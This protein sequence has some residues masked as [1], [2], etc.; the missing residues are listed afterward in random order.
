MV[1][2][3]T[4]SWAV[5][6]PDSVLP[7]SMIAVGECQ[8]L[9]ASLLR[10]LRPNLQ[11]H[12]PISWCGEADK[13]HQ[14]LFTRPVGR[15]G[16]SAPGNDSIVKWIQVPE[17]IA[18][19]EPCGLITWVSSYNPSFR[20]WSPPLFVYAVPTDANALGLWLRKSGLAVIPV[21][22]VGYWIAYFTVG[23]PSWTANVCGGH[24]S[25][26]VP[27]PKACVDQVHPCT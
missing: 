6:K 19:T 9:P 24:V 27:H 23:D 22:H 14:I 26:S 13:P 7:G 18:R 4:P 17:A 21:E 3:P 1:P 10:P 11:A 15:N 20:T 16:G 12:P 2:F 8:K 25:T 5:T